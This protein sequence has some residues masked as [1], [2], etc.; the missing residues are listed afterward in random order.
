MGWN[1]LLSRCCFVGQANLSSYL[2]FVF[3]PQSIYVRSLK[4][5]GKRLLLLIFEGVGEGR[6]GARV[7]EVYKGKCSH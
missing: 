7:S 6:K 3:F 2:L 1:F 4:R 5:T